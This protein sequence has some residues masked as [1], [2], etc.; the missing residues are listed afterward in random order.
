MMGFSEMYEQSEKIYNTDCNKDEYCHE[1]SFKRGLQ[2]GT[3]YAV[4]NITEWIKNCDITQ[5]IGVIYSGMCSITFHTDRFINDINE[6][7]KEKYEEK[8]RSTN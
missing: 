2:E 1:Q 7:N 6:M 4:N 3:K 8:I 5:Y